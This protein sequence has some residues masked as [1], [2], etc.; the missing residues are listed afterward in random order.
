MSGDALHHF[1]SQQHVD[2]LS[3]AERRAI[4]GRGGPGPGRRAGVVRAGLLGAV[5]SGNDLR[6]DVRA[7]GRK[8]DVP[9]PSLRR[10]H[11]QRPLVVRE[12]GCPGRS[13]WAASRTPATTPAGDTPDVVD[14]RQIDRVGTVM[15]AWLQS[16]CEPTCQR[17]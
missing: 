14:R 13:G 16:C 2:D 4:H 9:H 7:A 8:V 10:Q 1:G 15:W 3:R 12:G 17:R 11:H 6:A 5:A